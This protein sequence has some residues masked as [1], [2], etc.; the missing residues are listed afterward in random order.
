MKIE[1]CDVVDINGVWGEDEPDIL[2]LL[3][4]LSFKAA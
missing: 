3:N 2:L 1:F 4:E